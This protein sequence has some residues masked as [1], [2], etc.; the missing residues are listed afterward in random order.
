M[1]IRMPDGTQ[2]DTDDLPPELSDILDWQNFQSAGWDDLDW[3]DVEAL[4][5]ALDDLEITPYSGNK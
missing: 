1:Q 2:V 5:D 4:D 3:R